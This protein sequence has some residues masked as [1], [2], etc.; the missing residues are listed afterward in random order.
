M[1]SEVWGQRPKIMKT[2]KVAKKNPKTAKPKTTPKVAAKVE[3]TQKK[4]ISFVAI[5][6]KTWQELAAF[7]RPLA[8]V[9]L[10]YAVLYFIFVMSFSINNNVQEIISSTA[11]KLPQAFVVVTD[12]LFTSYNGS[13]SDATTLLQMLLF[14][15]AALALLWTLRR[16][17]NLQSVTI[18]EAYY[19]GP[20][21][22]VPVI[23]VSLLLMLTSIPALF[24]SS[25][26]GFVT[27]SS[28]SLAEFIIAVIFALV[29]IFISI[30]LFVTYWPAFYIVTLPNIRPIKALRM[31]AEVTKKNRLSI[32]RKF[33]LFG[34]FAMLFIVILALPIALVLPAIV[35]YVMYFVLFAL[36]MVMQVYLFVLYRSLV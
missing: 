2:K 10:T 9:T 29:M 23:I 11:G 20:A 22:I 30:L 32:L 27:Q 17:Q 28:S 15:T 4:L 14:L 13:Q 6:K 7:W 31:A 21:R 1:P 26:L 25:I 5:A 16:L 18:R 34:I 24:G 8:G 35:P 3:P 36:F 33:V 12:T 19:E